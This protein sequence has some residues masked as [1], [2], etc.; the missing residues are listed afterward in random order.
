MNSQVTGVGAAHA[1]PMTLFSPQKDCPRPTVNELEPMERRT[2]LNYYSCV[3][4]RVTLLA[5][6]ALAHFPLPIISAK[7]GFSLHE[8]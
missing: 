3:D 5:D 1:R 6:T 7:N 2:R 8:I 4:M